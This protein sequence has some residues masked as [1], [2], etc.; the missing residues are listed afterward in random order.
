MTETAL[1]RPE[2]DHTFTPTAAAV[3]PWDRAVVHGAAVV[4]LLAGQL[5][6]PEH[7]LARLSVDFLT[8]VPMA[9]LVLEH[10]E[11]AG[12]KRIKRQDAVLSCE[13]R[14]VATAHTITVRQTEL[15]LPPK[16]LDHPSPFDPAS[17]PAL[18]EPNRAAAKTVGWDSFDSTSLII[19]FMRV[20]GDRRVHAWIGMTV[21]VVEGTELRG[22]ELAAIAADYGQ[23]AVNKQL[24]F[25]TWS[26]RNAEQTLHLA[27]EPVGRW[28]GLRSEAVVQP[29]GA[30]FNTTDLFDA[31]GRVGRSSAALVVEQ[32]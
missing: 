18:E 11:P 21:P 25:G 28:I 6:P 17:M 9:P 10:S 20:K 3:G 2:G 16:A 26:F 7:T 22:T 31:D 32:R 24:P 8:T 19:D 27:R 15:E 29:V 30:G 12:G 4:A 23:T 14:P 13:G 5:S 1:F